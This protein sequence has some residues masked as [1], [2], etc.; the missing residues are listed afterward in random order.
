MRVLLIEPDKVLAATYMQALQLQGHIVDVATT[1]QQALI[2][3]DE[4]CPDIVVMEHQLSGT[5][6]IG[7]LQEFRSYSDWRQVPVIFHTMMPSHK[8]QV[9]AQLLT[10]EYGVVRWLYKPR[11]SLGELCSIV[12]QYG[13]KEGNV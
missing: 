9:A 3:A 5:N 11:T 10:K 1:A 13:G 7:F 4:N 6:G 2:A 12:S 8:Q